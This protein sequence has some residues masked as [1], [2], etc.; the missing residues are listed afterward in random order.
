[1]PLTVKLPVNFIVLAVNTMTIDTSN[2]LFYSNDVYKINPFIL[3][4]ATIEYLFNYI[5][6]SHTCIIFP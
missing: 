3:I 5:L 4:E 1:M 2:L 6:C